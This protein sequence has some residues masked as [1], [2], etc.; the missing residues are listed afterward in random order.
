MPGTPSER[1]RELGI[2]LPDPTAPVGSYSPV[3]VEGGL[4]WVSGQVVHAAGEAVHPGMVDQIV[5][6]PTAQGVARLATLQAL[7]ALAASLGSIDRIRRVLRV[8]VYVAVS[9]GFARPHEV[10]NGATDLLVEL[11]GDAGRPARAA[12]GVTA[13]PLGAPVEVEMTVAVG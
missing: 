10:A 7:G 9:P 6:V 12:I 13:L 8:T 11:F 5:D 3:V 2:R 1:L 4:A